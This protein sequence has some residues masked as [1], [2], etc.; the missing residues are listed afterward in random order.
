MLESELVVLACASLF[1]LASSFLAWWKWTHFRH[2]QLL[3]I[4]VGIQFVSFL[5]FFY[6]VSMLWLDLSGLTRESALFHRLGFIIGISGGF[7]LFVA[8]SYPH[9]SS[10]T[11]THQLF[12]V[13]TMAAFLL[14]LL[15][16]AVTIKHEMRESQ[17]L[18][19]Y[20]PLALLPLTYVGAVIMYLL[21]KHVTEIHAL[22][23]RRQIAEMKPFNP[24]FWLIKFRA[25]FTFTALFFFV[26][27]TFPDIRIP[28]ATWTLFFFGGILYF[29]WA[30]FTLP[31][32]VLQE[33]AARYSR[34]TLTDSH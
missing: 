11:R 18:I 27:R 7:I 22:V 1:A 19:H 23:K 25:F 8:L 12:I 33:K 16:N 20:H 21:E 30:L 10:T 2:W 6:F 13:L 14:A 9:V 24:T 32:S 15:G 28:L 34:K 26:A 4:A 17:L 3:M 31:Q 5:A 29:S